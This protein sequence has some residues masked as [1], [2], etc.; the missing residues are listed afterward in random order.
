MDCAVITLKA[1]ACKDTPE[2]PSVWEKEEKP[3]AVWGKQDYV[4]LRVDLCLSWEGFF[5]GFITGHALV[6]AVNDTEYR[7]VLDKQHKFT[8]LD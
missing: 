6:I 1:E 5:A 4:A 3:Q 8:H 2:L 7:N